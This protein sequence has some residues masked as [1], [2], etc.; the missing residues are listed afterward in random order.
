MKKFAT[1]YAVS[2]A[3]MISACA[4]NGTLSPSGANGI[5]AA[6]AGASAAVA[7]YQQSRCAPLVSRGQAC[8]P[9]QAEI[10]A[11][12]AIT[13]ANTVLAEYQANPTA[14][15]E[16]AVNG[17]LATVSQKVANVKTGG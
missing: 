1:L 10:D 15:N 3:V 7:A 5:S 11:Q 17:A 16:T 13:L 8:L 14:A 2:V 6:L 9:T 12:A 4:A